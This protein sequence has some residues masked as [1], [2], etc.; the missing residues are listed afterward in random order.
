MRKIIGRKG[1]NMSENEI[2]NKNND[3]IYHG[4][5]INISQKNKSLISTLDV[6]GKKKSIFGIITIYKIEVKVNEINN[7]INKIQENM[8][9]KILFLKQEF[10]AHFYRN[11]EMIIVFREKIFNVILDKNT[12]MEAINFGKSINIK[13]KQLDFI[14]NRFE[15]EQF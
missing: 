11:N 1:N 9:I 4:I 3:Q 13:E 5:I 8:A 10:Y 15:D 12:W 14:P 6:I 7:I 2:I